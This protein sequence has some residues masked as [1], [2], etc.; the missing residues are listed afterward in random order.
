MER[1][2]N[3]LHSKAGLQKYIT[4]FPP[5]LPCAY[6]IVITRLHIEM[7]SLEAAEYPETTNRTAC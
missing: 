1:S 7:W 6:V 3:F 2:G 5:L 4:I